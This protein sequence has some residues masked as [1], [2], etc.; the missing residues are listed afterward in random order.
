MS[1]APRPRSRRLTHSSAPVDHGSARAWLFAAACLIGLAVDAQAAGLTQADLQQVVDTY[2]GSQVANGAAVGVGVGVVVGDLRATFAYGLSNAATGEKFTPDSLFEIGSV[3]KVFT[4]N[5]LGQAVASKSTS[6]D[7]SLAQLSAE[8]GELKPETGTV[9]LEEM[10]DFTAGFPDKAP[11]C[12]PAPANPPHPTPAPVPGCLPNGRPTIAEY[13]AADFLKFFRNTVPK[14]YN[15][16]S[17]APVASV[18]A[19]YFYS[20][21]SIGLLGLVLGRTPNV[22]IDDSALTKWWRSVESQILTPLGMRRTYLDVPKEAQGSRAVGY[23]PTVAAV[24]PS[25]VGKNGAIET[26]AL[27][28]SGPGYETSPEVAITGGGGAGASAT[29]T[30]H[31]GV[32]TE[33]SVAKGAGGSGYI[34]APTVAFSGGGGKGA[35]GRVILSQPGP[36]SNP[37]TCTVLGVEIFDGGSGYTTAPTVTISGGL[38]NSAGS[39]ATATARVAGGAVRHVAIA[40]PGQGY[41]PALTVSVAPASLSPNVIPIWAPAGAISS[42]IRDM[43]AFASAALGESVVNGK[44][45][46]PLVTAGFKVAETPYACVGPYP[47]RAGCKGGGLSALAWAVSPAVPPSPGPAFPEVIVKNGGVPGFSTEVMLMPAQR[48]AVVVFVNEWDTTNTKEP[49]EPQLFQQFAQHIATNVINAVYY[50]GSAAP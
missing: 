43:T 33:I 34:A 35:M 22:P 29:A 5:L 9:T 49:G 24:L 1:V 47:F 6:L 10:G 42:T 3:T 26:I 37:N 40:N 18:P 36:G 13:G 48:I 17:P 25:G 30:V 46:D 27:I 28:N 45:I 12:K 11:Q 21:F 50:A 4:T 31:H 23:S 44:P 16:K 15:L 20:D 8:L 7:L 14:N 19:P 38:G 2:A 32:V 41:A 39:A